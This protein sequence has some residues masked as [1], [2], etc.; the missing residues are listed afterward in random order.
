MLGGHYFKGIRDR[1]GV[2]KAAVQPDKESLLAILSLCVVDPFARITECEVLAIPLPLT[3]ATDVEDPAPNPGHPACAEYAGSDYCRESWQLHLAELARRPRTHW[4][5][6]DYRRL[7]AIV[8]IVHQDRCLAA[9]KLACPTSMAEEDFE[10]HVELLDILV[11]GFVISHADLLK[12]LPSPEQ[13]LAQSA[14]TPS[15]RTGEPL[16]RQSR[17]PKVLK[18]LEYIDVHLSDPKLTIGCIA[19]ELDVDFSYLGRLFTDEVGQRM[20]W[21]IAARRVELAKTLLTT[22][23]RQIKRIARDAG[24]ANPNWFCHVFSVHTGLTP[25][26]YRRRSRHS[27]PPTLPR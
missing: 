1:R 4:H 18:A 27:S 10:R 21:F 9:V 3:A 2:R 16:D 22:T 11:E 5:K 15:H 24:Y 25:G 14:A 13:G 7:C 20:S 12:R 23:D 17:H 6:C 8:P 26:Q 19:R